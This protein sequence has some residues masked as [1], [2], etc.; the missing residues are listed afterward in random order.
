MVRIK[1]ILQAIDYLE[2]YG[3]SDEELDE[4]IGFDAKNTRSNCIFWLNDNN[5]QKAMDLKKGTLVCSPKIKDL[6]LEPGVN[7]I[8]VQSPRNAFRIILESFFYEKDQPGIIAESAKIHGSVIIGSNVS[9]GEH[10]VIEKQCVIG[11]NVRIDHNSVIKARTQIGNDVKVGCNT[12]IGCEGFGYEKDQDGIH[13]W[14]PHIGNVRIENNVEIG[15]NVSIDRAVIGSTLIGRHVKIDN[16]VHIAHGVEIGENSL[17]IANSMIAGSTK[18]GKNV[19]VAPSVSVL[20]KLEIADKAVLG[21]GAVVLKNVEAGD[22]IVG[23]PGK[24]LQK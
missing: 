24:K 10:V 16:L 12:T 15:N 20:N 2:F 14:I 22:I 17:V 18:I 5:I 4:M 13:R 11:D 19:H 21:M 3:N 9:I 6:P 7:Y 8:I 1:D 23:N